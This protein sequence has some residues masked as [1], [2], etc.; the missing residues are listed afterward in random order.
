[1]SKK[2][3]KQIPEDY[4]LTVIEENCQSKNNLMF[5]VCLFL[6]LILHLQQLLTLGILFESAVGVLLLVKTRTAR[7][8]QRIIHDA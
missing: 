8:R 5:S 3:L 4:F 1:M 7:D 2:I 6:H